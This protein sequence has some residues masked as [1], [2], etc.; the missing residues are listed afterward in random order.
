MVSDAECR[1]RV[2][3]AD[4]AK[5][6]AP[7]PEYHG[8]DAPQQPVADNPAESGNRKACGA[9]LARLEARAQHGTFR[10]DRRQH[11]RQATPRQRADKALRVPGPLSEPTLRARLPPPSGLAALLGGRRVPERAD[12]VAQVPERRRAGGVRG[13]RRR[14]GAGRAAGRAVDG[15]AA[16]VAGALGKPVAGGGTVFTGLRA[17]SEGRDYALAFAAGPDRARP[18]P[19]SSA[20]SRRRAGAPWPAG[21]RRRRGRPAAAA[22]PAAAA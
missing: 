20:C 10:L 15:V 22:W 4:R 1:L 5:P 11:G 7:P 18:S 3:C 2:A 9:R 21:R 8:P 6:T 19:R 14:G 12:G 13:A 16:R 17:D